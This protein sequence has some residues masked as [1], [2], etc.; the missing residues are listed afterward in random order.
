MS[1]AEFPDEFRE[2]EELYSSYLDGELTE[3]EARNFEATLASNPEERANFQAMKKTWEML[4]YLPKP[5]LTSSFTLRTME[6]LAQVTN[7]FPVKK[8]LFT[9]GKILALAAGI[10]ILITSGFRA[11][12]VF[13]GKS[14]NIEEELRKNLRFYENKKIY[15]LVENIEFLKKLDEPDLF[16]QDKS[17]L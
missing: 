16:G 1:N 6:K 15:D 2:K 17:D 14:D 13:V 9:I 8:Q 5:E 7:P 12:T 11:G 10:L 3:E 4:D